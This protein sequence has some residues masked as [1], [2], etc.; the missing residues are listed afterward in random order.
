MGICAY[1]DHDRRLTRE[2]LFPKFLTRRTP[3]G[4]HIDHGRPQKPLQA[5]TVIRDVCAAC[6][7]EVLGSLDGYAAKLTDRYFGLLLEKP[8]KVQFECDTDRLLRWL[9]KLLFNDARA[10]R[11]GLPERTLAYVLSYWEEIPLRA[12]R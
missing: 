10:S 2:E 6:N 5:I 9:L 7:N 1:C 11:G 8:V 3:K 4:A 12:W